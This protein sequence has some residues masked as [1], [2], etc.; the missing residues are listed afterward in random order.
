[1]WPGERGSHATVAQGVN[2]FKKHDNLEAMGVVASGVA[3]VAGDSLKRG[4]ELVSGPNQSL[5]ES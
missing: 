4:R 1:M 5:R 3:H 2:V